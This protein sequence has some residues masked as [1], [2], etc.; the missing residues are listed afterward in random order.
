MADALLSLLRK[1]CH[2][3]NIKAFLKNVK[4]FKV[5]HQGVLSRD[6]K[7]FGVTGE[8]DG[9]RTPAIDFSLRTKKVSLGDRSVGS[10][11]DLKY[12]LSMTLFFLFIFF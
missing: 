4:A 2:R 3:K 5:K 9:G 6:T 8:G 10:L 12:Y 11:E 1:F 7:R